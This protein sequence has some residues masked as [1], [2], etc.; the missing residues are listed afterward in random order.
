MKHFAYI[1]TIILTIIACKDKHDSD[2]DIHGVWTL[3]CIHVPEGDDYNY[4]ERNNTVP[5]KIFADSTYYVG[6]KVSEPG[7]FSFTPSYSGKYKLINKGGDEYL[8]VE[9]G[10]IHQFTAVNDSTINIQDV[11]RFYEWRKMDGS[12]DVNVEDVLTIL[13]N[14]KESWDEDRNSYIFT[15]TERTLKNERKY[16]VALF[17]CFVLVFAFAGYYIYNLFQTKARVEQ[18][19]KQIRKEIDARPEVVQEAL[20]SVEEEFLH[21][22]FYLSIRKRISNG[23][24]LKKSDWDEIE[25]Q[26]NSTYSGFT[27]RLYSLFPMSQTEL[28]TCLLI[29][30]RVPASEIASTLN[31]GASTISSIRSRLYGKAFKDKGG[32][33]EWDEFILSL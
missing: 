11:G 30:L 25:R 29:K 24:R 8:Y 28:Q 12:T 17:I 5:V 10:D 14:G 2:F 22:D 18:Q 20:K 15:A 4:K 3:E 31:K 21:S 7:M 16:F 26:I 13:D 6:H 32:A 1:F 27:S 23:D 33:K 9:D 19:L